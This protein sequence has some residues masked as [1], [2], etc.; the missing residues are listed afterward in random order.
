MLCNPH[1]S[2]Q[3][4]MCFRRKPLTLIHAV[5]HDSTEK[6]LLNLCIFNV[7]KKVY[8]FTGQRD[9]QNLYSSGILEGMVKTTKI[10]FTFQN[11]R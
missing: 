2:V 8:V 5:K 6:R 1:D 7:H 11:F 3:S 9:Y 4:I 10:H